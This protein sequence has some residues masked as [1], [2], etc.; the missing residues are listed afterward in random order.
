M[1]ANLIV[2][3]TKILSDWFTTRLNLILKY[4]IQNLHSAYIQ[5][6]T[7][8]ALRNKMNYK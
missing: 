5:A 7:A 8:A 3:H 6:T 4:F 2:I 1:I